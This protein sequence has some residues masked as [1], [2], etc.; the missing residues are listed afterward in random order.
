MLVPVVSRRTSVRA[1]VYPTSVRGRVR[2]S[3]R[4]SV[5]PTSVRVTVSRRTSVRVSVE[6]VLVSVSTGS[7]SVNWLPVLGSLSAL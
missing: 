2:V 6:L 1:S 3:V 4:V 5:N 7:V